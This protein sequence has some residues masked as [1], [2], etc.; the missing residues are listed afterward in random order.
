MLSANGSRGILSSL[1]IASLDRKD[2]AVNHV[3]L[4]KEDEAVKRFVL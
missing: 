3:A 4:G 2:W 1:T